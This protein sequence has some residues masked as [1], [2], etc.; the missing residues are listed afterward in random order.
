MHKGYLFNDFSLPNFL[1]KTLI[2]LL[3]RAYTA[4]VIVILD[5]LISLCVCVCVVGM[6]GLNAII[7]VSRGG[8]SCWCV[9]VQLW[10]GSSQLSE[11][12]L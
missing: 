11:A 8:V 12:G 5:V 6:C 2:L 1:D 4:C 7:T 3:L 9:C 10:P